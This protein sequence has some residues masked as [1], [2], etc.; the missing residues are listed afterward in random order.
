MW[1]D[2]EIPA[3]LDGEPTRL[4]P[5]SNISFRDAAFRA[6]VPRQTVTAGASA[7]KA[8]VTATAPAVES[9]AG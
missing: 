3:V 6:L 1:S 4:S 2:E 5:Q 8:D 7:A 9:R